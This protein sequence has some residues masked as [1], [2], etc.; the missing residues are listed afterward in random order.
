MLFE[1]A[2]SLAAG[3]AAHYINEEA[4]LEFLTPEVCIPAGS[5]DRHLHLILEALAVTQR[6]TETELF[7]VS[8]SAQTAQNT[9]AAVQDMIHDTISEKTERQPAADLQKL[10]SGRTFSVILTPRSEES[11]PAEI[12]RFA[13]I[14]SFERT[15]NCVY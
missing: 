7:C 6:Q 8:E 2:V 15:H 13:R 5:G 10:I 14:I 9:G 4:A 3:L 11:F 12:R 1:K